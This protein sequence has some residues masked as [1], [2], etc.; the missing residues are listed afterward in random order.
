MKVYLACG[1]THVPREFFGSYVDFIHLAAQHLEQR[2]GAEVK[3][4]LK[5]SDPQLAERPADQRAM[6]EWADIVVAECSFPSIGVGIE[7][8]IAEQN[9]TPT[10]ICFMRSD[11]TVAPPAGYSNP[12]GSH[13]HLQIGDGYVTL[14]ALG[15]P[16]VRRVVAYADAAEGI[17]RMGEAFSTLVTQ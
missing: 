4:A 1:L 13:H 10:M 9:N 11:R 3:Y 15:L 12:D 6:V 8:Q 7:L 5:H 14:M 17:R 16:S 2:C